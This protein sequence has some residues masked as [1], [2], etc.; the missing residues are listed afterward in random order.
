MFKNL[1][2]KVLGKLDEKI[3]VILKVQIVLILLLAN[4]FADFFFEGSLLIPQIILSLVYLY[5]VYQGLQKE[6]TDEKFVFGLLFLGLFIV[7]E[8]IFAFSFF[9]ITFMNSPML[10]LGLIFFVILI[11]T[12][13]SLMLNKNFVYGEIVVSEKDRAIVKTNFSLSSFLPPGE[14]AVQSDKKFKKGQK[15]KV[16]VKKTFFGKKPTKVLD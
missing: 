2:S 5:F 4:G 9:S 7:A 12:C 13:Y 11:Y 3:Y 15:V 16:E 8:A 14:Y 10:V 1:F 6:F